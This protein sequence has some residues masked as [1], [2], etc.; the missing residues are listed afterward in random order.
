MAP[1]AMAPQ[2]T[3]LLTASRSVALGRFTSVLIAAPLSGQ[4]SVRGLGPC[5]PAV[6][7][8]RISNDLCKPDARLVGCDGPGV[9]PP[10]RAPDDVRTP[11]G[12]VDEGWPGPRDGPSR[13]A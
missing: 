7:G 2:L 10:G 5:D 1:A 11:T 12:A 3:R 13:H 9:A 6:R 4:V 8:R